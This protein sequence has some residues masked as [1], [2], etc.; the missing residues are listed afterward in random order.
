MHVENELWSIN[1]LGET[2]I[3]FHQRRGRELPA[4]LSPFQHQWAKISSSSV[5]RRRQSGAAAANNDH[6]LHEET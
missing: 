3:I 5:N 6:F 2:G 1:S 4:G